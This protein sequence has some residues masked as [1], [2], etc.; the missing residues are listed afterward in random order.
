MQLR[1]LIIGMLALVFG[2]SAAMGVYLVS[3]QPGQSPEAELTSIVFATKNISRG[4][5]V[6][7]EDLELRPWPK[8]LLPAG[9]ITNIEDAVDRGVQIPLLPD[10]PLL[11]TKLAAKGSGRGMSLLI[12][13]G[14]R[15]VTIQTPN[16]S[17]GM[18]GFILPGDKVDVLVTL[19]YSGQNDVSGG[20]GTITL[21]Q[22]VEILAVD[23]RIEAPS[24]NVV[25][26]REL[27]SVT[28]L[29]TPHEA[30]RLDLGQNKG[31][32]SLALRNPQDEEKGNMESA[33]LAGLRSNREPEPSAFTELTP[34][35]SL[36]EFE[37]AS[38]PVSELVTEP[39][40]EP[41]REAKP[42]VLPA[43]P[44]IRTLRGNVSSSV[45]LQP[46]PDYY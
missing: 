23:Q 21:L 18:A 9:A 29:V 4:S 45:Q 33:T 35:Q 3:K 5:N 25:D 39:V 32:L 40:S 8:S 13:P 42:R 31:T 41:V 24:E 17:T 2:G 27:R 7:A 22:N 20:S 16:V 11:E 10:E 44:P 1:T 38:E 34:E 43:H 26:P 30:A 19:S 36:A 28:L 6:K 46:V 12:P 37:P 15:A 14:M